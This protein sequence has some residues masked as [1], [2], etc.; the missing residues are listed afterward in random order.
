MCIDSD[1]LHQKYTMKGLALNVNWAN[2]PRIVLDFEIL[3]VPW[4]AKGELGQLESYQGSC[5]S[6][7]CDKWKCLAIRKWMVRIHNNYVHSLSTATFLLCFLSAFI[8]GLA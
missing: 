8:I 2:P 4:N 6:V 7:T 3:P 1:W 5:L